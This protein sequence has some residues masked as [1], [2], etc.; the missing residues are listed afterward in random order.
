MNTF[1]KPLVAIFIYNLFYQVSILSSEP[2]C[3]SPFSDS[4][5]VTASPTPRVITKKL[6]L[7]MSID[8]VE[9]VEEEELFGGYNTGLRADIA[10]ESAKQYF[11]NKG[12]R[13][14]TE[15]IDLE[16]EKYD[17]GDSSEGKVF[18]LFRDNPASSF[19]WK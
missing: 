19:E 14:T 4:S 17:I 5:S 3:L 2:T 6:L 7:T 15:P 11:R 8:L 18:G 10:L 16:S 13:K 9:A 1:K 12:V